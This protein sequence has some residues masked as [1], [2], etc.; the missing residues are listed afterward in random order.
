LATRVADGGDTEPMRYL[1]GALQHAASYGGRQPLWLNAL[2]AGAI[3][4]PISPSAQA[5]MRAQDPLRDSRM[6]IA[7]GDVPSP[8]ESF[9]VGPKWGH[10][11]HNWPYSTEVSRVNFGKLQG[12]DIVGSKPREH[13]ILGATVTQPEGH[14]GPNRAYLIFCY[15]GD[16]WRF[17]NGTAGGDSQLRS[18]PANFLL[19]SERLLSIGMQTPEAFGIKNLSLVQDLYEQIRSH[20]QE[21]VTSIDVEP[22]LTRWRARE[23]PGMTGDV[24]QVAWKALAASLVGPG[25]L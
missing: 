9:V 7:C 23:L 13:V 15:E 3:V 18:L 1:A 20:L 10:P 17:T 14:R 11:Y 25:S 24:G 6:T 21:R 19:E 2:H 4:E 16:R 12:L 22:I 5:L 8:H